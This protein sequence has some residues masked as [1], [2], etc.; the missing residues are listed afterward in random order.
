[1]DFLFIDGDNTYEGVK[2]DFEMYSLLVR[3]GGVIAFHDICP[4]P[5]ETGC[6]V[7]RFWNKVKQR[8]K[9]AEIVKDCNQKWSGICVLYVSRGSNRV[10]Y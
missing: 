5:P 9:Y 3:N 8:Y 1:V 7:S 6:E 10:L 4:H 2:K